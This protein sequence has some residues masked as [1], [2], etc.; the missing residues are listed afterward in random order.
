MAYKNLQEFIT[1]LDKAGELKRISCEVD[2]ELEI[3]EITD[4][5][6]K[7]HGPAL[8]FENVKGSDYP[9]LTNS[10]GSYKRM[11]MALGSESIEIKAAELEELMEWGFGQLRKIDLLSFFP[12]VKW[13]RLFLPHR[14]MHAPCQQVV[15]YEPDLATIPV[16][17]CWPGDGGA[18]ITL[19]IVITRDPET[20]NQNVGMYRMQIF[21]RNTTGMH[22]HLHKDGA[23][24]FQKYKE[25]G[26]RM[27][28][29][30]AL[31]DDPAVTYAAT[32]PLP[33]GI[34]E[35]FF[36]GYLR[37]KPVETVTCKTCDLE[38]PAQA[39][40]IL[41]GYVDPNEPL[42]RE[43]PFGDH[44]G[45]YSLADEYPVF[46]VTCITRRKNPVYP[47]TIVGKPPMEDCYMAKA[48]E[49][50][51]LPLL[52]KVVPEIVDMNLPLEGVLP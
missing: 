43:G 20:G 1:A 44:T 38:V 4:R 9:V 42:R 2:A 15:E 39:E 37:G 49:R 21:D 40:F 30:V 16:L 28:V 45:Y 33:E 36:A 25:R 22:W 27:P 11:A 5:V 48:T 41:E 7:S 32:A 47:A 46:H 31:G 17:K 35:L 24:I 6:S 8:L 34:S 19:P 10:M 26:E 52:R 18:F 13:A 3:T 51:F 14:V 12:K 50:L 23:H 29:A